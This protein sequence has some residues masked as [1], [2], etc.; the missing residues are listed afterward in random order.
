[1]REAE[2][3]QARSGYFP[4]VSAA[5]QGKLGLS[6]TTR[7]LGLQ[8]LVSSPFYRNLAS[9]VHISQ[10][11]FDFGRTDHATRSARY[12]KQAAEYGLDAARNLV[13]LETREAYLEALKNQSLTRLDERILEQ[14]RLQFRKVEALYRSGIRSKLDLSQ[15]EFQVR[16][17]EANLTEHP[18]LLRRSRARLDR[19]MGREAAQQYNLKHVP[20]E[21]TVPPGARGAN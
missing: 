14:R 7:G 3:A 6:G 12:L 5:G 1:M 15:A 4:Q 13:V 19:A 9:S 20:V 16:E 10:N 18:E 2:V 11:L 8:G 17:V 21:P